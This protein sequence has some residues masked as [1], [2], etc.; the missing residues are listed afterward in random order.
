MMFEAHEKCVYYVG[1]MNLKFIDNFEFQ[2]AIP[3]LME[4]S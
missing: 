2:V 3:N 4:I 1:L